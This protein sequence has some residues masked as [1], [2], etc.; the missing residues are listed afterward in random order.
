MYKRSYRHIPILLL[1][2]L[3]A[4]ISIDPLTGSI[5]RDGVIRIRKGHHLPLGRTNS[6]AYQEV[7]EGSSVL[8]VYVVVTVSD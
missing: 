5:I 4:Q 7:N 2:Q 6:F 3:L 8:V 1:V